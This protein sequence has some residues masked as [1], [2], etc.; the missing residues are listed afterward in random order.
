[1]GK[2]HWS[3]SFSYVQECARIIKHTPERVKLSSQ[4]FESPQFAIVFICLTRLFYLYSVIY[5][6]IYIYI[7]I[8]IYIHLY[9]YI[10][11]Y[12]Y[13]GC[14]IYIYHVYIYLL[15]WLLKEWV[16][17]KSRIAFSWNFVFSRDIL[18]LSSVNPEA[19][20]HTHTSIY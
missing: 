9:I 18:T 7:F 3:I 16:F 10:Y 11:L 5:I 17:N 13:H 20:A 19:S 4:M 15:P 6:Y 12:I 2:Q 8:Y 1:M 14:N